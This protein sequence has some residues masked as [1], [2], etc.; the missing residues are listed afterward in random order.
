M[1]TPHQKAGA[2][3]ARVYSNVDDVSWHSIAKDVWFPGYGDDYSSTFSPDPLEQTCTPIVRMLRPRGPK[4]YDVSPPS[5]VQPGP[6][7][8]LKQAERARLRDRFQARCD[9]PTP[10]ED[11]LVRLN[12]Q[13]STPSPSPSPVGHASLSST[14]EP[15]TNPSTPPSVRPKLSSDR[16]GRSSL[17]P[18]GRPKKP[19]L[20]SMFIPESTAWSLPARSKNPSPPPT[21]TPDCTGRSTLLLNGRP[22]KPSPSSMVT[23]ESTAWS[24]P[25]RSKN[26]SPP[27]T[28]T[29][30]RT[31][32]RIPPP[33]KVRLKSSS[34]PPITAP[35]PTPRS[36]QTARPKGPPP[37]EAQSPPKGGPIRKGRP[38][39][40]R[41]KFEVWGPG[42]PYIGD[43]LSN[44]RVL[45]RGGLRYHNRVPEEWYKLK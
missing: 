38:P 6:P 36:T 17:L 15:D 18:N 14:P 11:T 2:T 42:A 39:P 10:S 19:S 37:P 32:W 26:P 1:Q 45:T 23:P 28:V 13:D 8:V 33:T 40:T 12:R 44:E 21:V 16:T 35:K 9:S 4:E 20:S 27:L 30:D 24:L 31:A 43:F 3:K 22:N 7:I 34:H 41:E 5:F 25:P 29:P